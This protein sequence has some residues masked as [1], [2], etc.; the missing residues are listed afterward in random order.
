MSYQTLFIFS[1]FLWIHH[2]FR[3]QHNCQL[4]F[5]L[6]YSHFISHF[7][8]QTFAFLWCT[9]D[10]TVLLL[11]AL[12][13]LNVDASQA[14]QI[15]A[16]QHAFLFLLRNL[17]CKTFDEKYLMKTGQQMMLLLLIMCI[18]WY[19]LPEANSEISAFGVDSFSHQTCVVC[20]QLHLSC[21]QVH[22]HDR[23][24]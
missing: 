6:L 8:S 18:K 11:F 21:T 5:L 1:I 15:K 14:I 13:F 2:M 23:G 10:A 22:F 9:V 17:F 24:W 7:K 4:L 20:R 12:R 3:A 19:K 16:S